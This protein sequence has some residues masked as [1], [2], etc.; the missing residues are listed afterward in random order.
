MQNLVNGLL[1]PH[2]DYYNL[3]LWSSV[4][5]DDSTQFSI[6]A[7]NS[8]VMP[9][10][11]QYAPPQIPTL[12]SNPLLKSS[13][14]SLSSWFC[15]PYLSALLPHCTY[16]HDLHGLQLHCPLLLTISC[17]LKWIILFF[18]AWNYLP[19]QLYKVSSVHFILLKTHFFHK[20]SEISDTS[21][22]W[23]QESLCVHQIKTLWC[24]LN[25]AS[26]PSPFLGNLQFPE[27]RLLL[28]KQNHAHWWH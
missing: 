22:T 8:L 9:L 12:A 28:K 1:I 20:P 7:L 11:S 26:I 13:C 14:S 21:F 10:C 6:M 15:P 24:L 3:L 5:S 16:T 18:Y 17:F 25:P 27:A 19:D 23:L 4:A 2:L